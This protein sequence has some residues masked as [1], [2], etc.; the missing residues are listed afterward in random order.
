MNSQISVKIFL[1]A[2]LIKYSADGKTRKLQVSL[3]AGSTINDLI[4]KLGI[5]QSEHNLLLS[6]NGKVAEEKQMIM[7]N[8]S[9]HLMIPLSGG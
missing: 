2:T 9:V 5:N 8:D 1:H 6:I 3:P 4:K 7:D